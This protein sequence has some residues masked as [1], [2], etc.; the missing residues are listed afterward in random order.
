[1]KRTPTPTPKQRVRR[2]QPHA[3]AELSAMH[4]WQIIVYKDAY[5]QRRLGRSK[6]SEAAAW[7]NADRNLTRRLEHKR[8]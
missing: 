5:Y 1:M 3:F 4:G 7:G 6:R 2:R 8:G